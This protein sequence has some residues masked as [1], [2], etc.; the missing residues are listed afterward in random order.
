M[1]EII[2]LRDCSIDSIHYFAISSRSTGATGRFF[3]HQHRTQRL[4][5]DEKRLKKKYKTEFNNTIVSEEKRELDF[6]ER[7]QA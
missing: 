4:D 5:L 2:L 1:D 7:G 6:G 3:Y